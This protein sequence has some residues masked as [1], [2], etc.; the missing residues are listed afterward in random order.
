MNK[1]VSVAREYEAQIKRKLKKLSDGLPPEEY[2]VRYAKQELTEAT[3]WRK[4]TEA[5]LAA[6]NAKKAGKIRVYVIAVEK[7]QTTVKALYAEY[8]LEQAK[9][10]K[11]ESQIQRCTIK[12]PCAGIV[13]IAGPSGPHSPPVREGELARERQ[14]LMRILPDPT[15]PA[16]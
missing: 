14:V 15:P 5:A 16:P 7:A 13:G 11:L 10:E 4:Q 1:E 2:P 9:L 3:V 8:Q 12:A 6:F